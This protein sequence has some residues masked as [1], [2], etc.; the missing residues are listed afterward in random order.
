MKHK[1]F[2]IAI[3]LCLLPTTAMFGQELRKENLKGTNSASPGTNYA[4]FY[5]AG[6]PESAIWPLHMNLSKNGVTIRHTP[7][8]GNGSNISVNDKVPFRFVIAPT[9]GDSDGNVNW[10]TAM[11]LNTSENNNLAPDGEGATTGCASYSTTEFP[12]GWRLPTQREMMLMWLF[13]DG[14]KDIYTSTPLVAGETYWTA[15]ENDNAGQA[16]CFVN[17]ETSPGSSTAQKTSGY[18]FRCVRDY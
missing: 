7:A 12:N 14:I 13:R 10:A 17:S 3:V 8:K 18:K 9:Q 2:I 6:L 1:L 5:S 15:T 4:V 11:G 16:W